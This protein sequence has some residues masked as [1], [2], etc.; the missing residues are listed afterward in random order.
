MW[1]VLKVQKGGD[2]E[3]QRRKQVLADRQGRAI[4]GLVLVGGAGFVFYQINGAV[5]GGVIG[6][7]IGYFWDEIRIWLK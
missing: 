6:A 7:L 1:V 2:D 3:L 5:V 4:T